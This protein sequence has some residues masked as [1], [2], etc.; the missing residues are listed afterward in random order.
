MPALAALMSS[1]MRETYH[2]TWHGSPEA[3]ALDG[4]GREFEMH[5]A[6]TGDDLLGLAAWRKAYDLHH[7]I[8]GAEVFDMFVVPAVRGRSIGASLICAV[9]AEVLQRGG[10]F[11]KGQAVDDLSVRRLYERVSVSFVAVECM[12]AGRALRT[13]ASL[14]SA[15]PRE[16][17]RSLPP[18]AWNYEA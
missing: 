16:M 6:S 12:L 15:S 7:C 4:F 5:V 17:V 3:M 14:A 1:Y 9:A 10:K 11:L 13:M 8:S 18:K 2:D